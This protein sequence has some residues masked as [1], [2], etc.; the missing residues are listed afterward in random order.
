MFAAQSARMARASSGV[1]RA[2]NRLIAWAW[3][4]ENSGCVRQWP[5][6]FLCRP[7]AGAGGLFAPNRHPNRRCVDAKS[8]PS[9]F[10]PLEGDGALFASTSN[11]VGTFLARKA[12]RPRPE[13][14]PA[15]LGPVRPHHVIQPA[16]LAVKHVTIQ[17]QECRQGLVPGRSRSMA[18]DGQAGQKGA[19]FGGAHSQR[20]PLVVKE[21]PPVTGG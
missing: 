1:N 18:G 7:G 13:F 20:M 17:K 21:V 15:Q 11:G 8:A 3:V 6:R 2:G 12:P 19:D 14:S 10:A 5:F 16:K 9:P 4:G